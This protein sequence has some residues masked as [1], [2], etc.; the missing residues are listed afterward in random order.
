[1]LE[2]NKLDS[3]GKRFSMLEIDDDNKKESKDKT[4]LAS[5][6]ERFSSLEFE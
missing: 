2:F 1:M 6:N 3:V 4:E 5:I